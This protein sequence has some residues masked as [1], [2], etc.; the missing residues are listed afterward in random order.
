MIWKLGERTTPKSWRVQP[1]FYF[2][3][4]HTTNCLIKN[5]EWQKQRKATEQWLA[6]LS[7]KITISKTLFSLSTWHSY[8]HHSGIIYVM[9]IR[10]A[11]QD[12]PNGI[13]RRFLYFNYLFWFLYMICKITL[14]M[15]HTL[16]NIVEN[17]SHRQKVLP[18]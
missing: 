17:N 14:H 11:P 6:E 18:Y 12:K 15:S 5:Y 10:L 16:V 7:I 3:F 2:V 13:A 9:S 4:V 1:M 8:S